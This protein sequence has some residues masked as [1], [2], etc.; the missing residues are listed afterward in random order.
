MPAVFYLTT[1]L[2]ICGEQPSNPTTEQKIQKSIYQKQSD[3]LTGCFFLN[4]DTHKY[5]KNKTCSHNT[6]RK[7]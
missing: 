7:V 1:M 2:S 6:Y 5:S 3:L 4:K